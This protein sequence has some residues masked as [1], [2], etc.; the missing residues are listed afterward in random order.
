VIS[1]RIYS[2]KYS[3]NFDFVVWSL[4]EIHENWYATKNSEFTSIDYGKNKLHIN[5]MI[6]IYFL[7]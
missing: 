4:D 6:K 5:E 2:D 3:L 7:Y 1:Q